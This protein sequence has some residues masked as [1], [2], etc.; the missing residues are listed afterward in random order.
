MSEPIVYWW[1]SDVPVYGSVPTNWHSPEALFTSP[2]LLAIAQRHGL[3]YARKWYDA[4]R[5]ALVVQGFMG[6]LIAEVDVPS[7]GLR[8]D[9]ESAIK[10][11]AAILLNPLNVMH[12]AQ[13]A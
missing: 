2:P 13:V 9:E 4:R 7:E 8:H 1:N 6:K 10:R 11:L 12:E 5:E 3:T